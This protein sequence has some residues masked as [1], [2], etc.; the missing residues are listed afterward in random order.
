[1]AIMIREDMTSSEG[2][3]V[4]WNYKKSLQTT[5]SVNFDPISPNSIMVDY[6]A[7]HVGLTRNFT[8]YTEEALKSS[9]ATWTKP[10]LRPLIMH[11]NEKDGKIIGRIHH[12]DY[13]DKNTL[14]GTGALLLTANVPDKEGIEGIQ[15]GRLKTTSIGAIVHEAKCSICNQNIAE[16]GP[17]EHE[18]GV[19]YDDKLCY[20]IITKMEAKELSYVIVPSDIYSQHTRVYKPE[21]GKVTQVSESFENEGVLNMS[22]VTTKESTTVDENGE[23]GTTEQPVVPAPTV[24]TSKFEKEIEALKEDKFAL[25]TKVKE[26]ETSLKAEQDEKADLAKTLEAT[27]ILLTK[28]T[29]DIVK[30]KAALTTKESEL[31]KEITLR[32]SLENQLITDKVN[33]RNELVESVMEL[34]TKLNKRPMAKE[35]LEKKSDEF[36][37]ESLMDLQE[38]INVSPA[39]K[40]DVT[41][42]MTE[43]PEVTNPGITENVEENTK[44]NVKEEKQSSNINVEEAF[45][46]IMSAMMVPNKNRF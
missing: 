36:L 22:D 21:K 35:D 8:H 29:E 26:L 4:T 34:R 31:E 44:P 38:E 43:V 37:Q 1:M 17:C 33:K 19:E 16:Y 20:W 3:H 28:A 24:D 18:R 9:I 12:A 15:D 30:V 40:V 46:E 23:A 11:H 14:S 13:T 25:E 7:I 42:A 41:E 10:Y 32:E 6:E 5:E 27:Q 39:H 2:L 45:A